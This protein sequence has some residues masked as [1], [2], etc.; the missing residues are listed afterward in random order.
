MLQLMQLLLGSAIH[1]LY[2]AMCLQPLHT[3]FHSETTVLV[4]PKRDVKFEFSVS[5]G[6]YVPSF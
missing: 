1:A 4:T 5:V 3:T 2:I 6:P